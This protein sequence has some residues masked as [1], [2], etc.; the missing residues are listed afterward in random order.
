MPDDW[1][2]F[3][4]NGKPHEEIG[5]LPEAPPWR[6]F[7]V[8]DAATPGRR[9]GD[10]ER[11]VAYRADERVID[12]VNAALLLRRPLLVTG[13]P[14]SGKSTLAYG[15]AHELG[16]EPVLYWPVTSRTTLERGL[17]N[18]DAI[19]RLHDASLRNATGDGRGAPPDIGRYL[20][21]GPL[22]TAFLPGRRPRVLLIDELDKS[23]IDLPNDLL[24]VFEEGCFSIPELARLPEDQQ[25]VE[26]L[27]AD[28]RD[29]VPVVGGQ[30]CCE[31]FPIIVIT[32][33]GEREFPPAFLRRCVRMVIEPPSAEQLADIVE[34]HLGAD[35]RAAG[36]QLIEQFMARRLQGDLAT[37]QLLN[38]IYLATSGTRLPE[39]TLQ[40]LIETIMQP[41]DRGPA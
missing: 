3:R 38:A 12:K 34:A 7:G 6:R 36:L 8:T 13:K 35:S 29:R 37:D 5:E 25:T 1:R 15:I 28:G 2:I 41:L 27:T 4:G 22:G 32:S 26:V 14:G 31:E 21:L 19:G 33:N 40:E 17:Y 24:A 11:A 39:T 9:L 30:V 20:R 10:L 18:Y 16:L 23:D